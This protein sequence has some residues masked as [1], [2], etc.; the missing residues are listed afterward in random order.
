MHGSPLPLPETCSCRNHLC[1]SEHNPSEHMAVG[2]TGLMSLL[3]GKGADTLSSIPHTISSS[4][5]PT[6]AMARSVTSNIANTVSCCTDR[7]KIPKPIVHL[8]HKI[9]VQRFGSNTAWSVSEI[10]YL[11]TSVVAPE[12]GN[13]EHDISLRLFESKNRYQWIGSSGRL[14]PDI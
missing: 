12:S 13:I 4:L 10:Q 3:I 14:R 9:G 7:N 5:L 1:P 11:T 8:A 6:C 2:E